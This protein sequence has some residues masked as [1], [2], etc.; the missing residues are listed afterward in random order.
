MSSTVSDAIRAGDGGG[1][2]EAH[3]PADVVHEQMEAAESERVHGGG[4]KAAE[5]G[6]GVVEGGRAVGEP[7]PGQVE[8]D[9]AQATHGQLAQDLAVQKLEAG[10]PCR[11]TTGSP[12][13]GPASRTKLL[14]P[15]A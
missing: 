3:R 6:P 15:A 2:L 5:P 1:E 4:A 11:H 13:G 8:R 14:I 12:A 9:P 7:E 10:T